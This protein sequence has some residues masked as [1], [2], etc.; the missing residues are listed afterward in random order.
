MLV[1]LLLLVAASSC[2]ASSC[3][4]LSISISSP[5]DGFVIANVYA[6][7]YYYTVTN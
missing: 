7:M 3:A 5:L 4:A 6:Y 2:A 1:C